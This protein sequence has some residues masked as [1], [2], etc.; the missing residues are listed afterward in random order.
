[1]FKLD[2]K[3]LD[4]NLIGNIVIL[5]SIVLV[6]MC[7]FMIITSTATNL[8]T[9]S[10]V[11]WNGY[12]YFLEADSNVEVNT[13]DTLKITS[14]YSTHNI[15]LKKTRDQSNFKNHFGGGNTIFAEWDY[16]STHKCISDE[17]DPNKVYAVIV[18]S[19]AI[20]MKTGHYTLKENTEFI[21]VNA[22]DSSYMPSFISSREE[23]I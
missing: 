19:D 7:V 3:N 10:R 18:P 12:R 11:E 9:D 13:D 5:L 15:E 21:E 8:T 4:A 17:S 2:L 6:I 22:E 23:V 20:E 1:M 14:P 16:N